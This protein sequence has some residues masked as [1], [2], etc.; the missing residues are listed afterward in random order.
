MAKP[1]ANINKTTFLNNYNIV[2]ISNDIKTIMK[3]LETF[4][5]NNQV[6]A[7]GIRKQPRDTAPIWFKEYAL[8]QDKFNQTILTRLNSL[9]NLV[10]KVV[11]LNNLKTE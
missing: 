3:S 8:K 9:E 4:N 5:P 6:V 11:K 1:L 7:F 2:E 10:L